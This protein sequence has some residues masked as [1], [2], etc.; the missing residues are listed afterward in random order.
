MSD[1]RWLTFSER[2]VR[3][4]TKQVRVGS[5]SSPMTL[6]YIQW[7][8]RWRQYAFFPAV[9]TVFSQDCLRDIVQE[10]DRLMAERKGTHATMVPRPK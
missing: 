6:G 9:N 5:K 2:P 10:I 3:G 1:Y 7:F 8:G 4:K